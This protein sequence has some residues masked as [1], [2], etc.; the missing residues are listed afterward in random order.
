[1]KNFTQHVWPVIRDRKPH[2]SFTIVGRNPS[3]EVLGLSSNHGV[4]VTGSVDD[5]RPFYR[6][7]IAAVVPLNVGGGSRLKILEA[8]AASVP[9]VSTTLG[10]EGLEVS[11]GENILLAGSDQ[12]IAGAI[13]NLID[14][15]SL[16]RRLIAGGQALAKSRY[17]W[18]SLGGKLVDEYQ[19][20]LAVRSLSHGK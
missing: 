11:N 2:L 17:D 12:E 19:R 4:E 15:D 18:S 20:L 8:M 14:D 7:A 6:E 5:V 13:I 10:A 1:V 9:V 3:A 16:R